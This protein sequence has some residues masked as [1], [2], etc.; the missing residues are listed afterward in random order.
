ML[1]QQ[2]QKNVIMDRKMADSTAI[3]DEIFEKYKYDY[4]AFQNSVNYYLRKPGKFARIFK[5]A[6]TKLQARRDLLL[7]QQNTEIRIEWP[8]VDFI[9]NIPF[10]ELSDNPYHRSL[11][12]VLFPTQLDTVWTPVVED[13]F[14]DIPLNAEWW[15]N[16]IE[17]SKHRYPYLLPDHTPTG[18]IRID[19]FDSKR[20]IEPELENRD[21]RI[22]NF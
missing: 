16:N 15:I 14:F 2:V 21:D 18:E 1:D 17:Y 9:K 4:V 12:W 11:K 5:K 13:M 6:Q 22:V 10:K 3:Y 7:S 8:M 19:N 20:V